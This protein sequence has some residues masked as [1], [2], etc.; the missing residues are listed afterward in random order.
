MARSRLT[1][2][3]A[4]GPNG[5]TVACYP[6]D[7]DAPWLAAWR[8]LAGRAIVENQFYEPDYVLAGANAFGAGLSVLIVAD[9]SPREPGARLLALWPFRPTQ[10]WGLPLPVLEGWEHGFSIFGA[11]LVDR[12]AAEP[13][14][15]ALL[16]APTALRLPPRLLM[17]YLPLEGELAELFARVQIKDR[18][19]RADVSVHARGF[20]D[21]RGRDAAA[22][23]G[24]LAAH[25]SANKARQLARLARRMEA[26]APVAFETLEAPGQLG[27]AL[28]DYLALERSGWKG[29]VGTAAADNPAQTTFLRGI[30]TAYGAAG[31]LRIDR[32]R[33]EGQ[34]LAVSIGLR[35]E[36]T[37]WYLKISYAED[38][39]KNSPGSQLVRQVTQT[40][41]DDPTL[42]AAD[43][44]APA[45]LGM[46]STFWCE[47]RGLS[48][49]L[50]EAQGGD[51]LF[52]LAA[53]CEAMRVAVIDQARRLRARLR[54]RLGRH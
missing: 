4:P 53:R 35:T 33:R 43:S 25:L 28:E 40:L 52:P 34:S 49:A 18:R 17:P 9:R 32:L 47:R 13:A 1:P 10:R 42:D 23:K 45:S 19:R 8:D 48:H 38:E 30:V 31:R 20:L 29:R 46:I 14:L 12:E 50:I 7:A 11:P 6:L 24:Y 3:E 21:L 5:L 36:R 15:C 51:R 2:R 27:P 16:A 54:A 22:R 26:Q 44:C 41:L 37:F 39:A